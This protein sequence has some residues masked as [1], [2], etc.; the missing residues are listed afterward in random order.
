MIAH[1]LKSYKYSKDQSD[2]N[3]RGYILVDSEFFVFGLTK[4]IFERLYQPN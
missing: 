1:L 3:K 4:N 2:N